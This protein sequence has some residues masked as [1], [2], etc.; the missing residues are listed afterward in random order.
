[1]YNSHVDVTELINVIHESNCERSIFYED[2]NVIYVTLLGMRGLFYFTP[3][4]DLRF[5]LT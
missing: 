4:R 5:V 3:G 1:V 2:G